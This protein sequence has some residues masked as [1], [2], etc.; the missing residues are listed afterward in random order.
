MGG[1]K[2]V[3]DYSSTGFEHLWS[4]NELGYSGTAVLTGLVASIA[5]IFWGLSIL[6]EKE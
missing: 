4:T 5:L 2:L 1:L 3:G 6:F